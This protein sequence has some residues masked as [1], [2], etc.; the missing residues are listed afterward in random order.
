MGIVKTRTRRLA[1]EE[2]LLMGSQ[3]I[4]ATVGLQTN[5]LR[6]EW[7]RIDNEE[8][9]RLFELCSQASY[10][11]GFNTTRLS[12]RELRTW[13][14]LVEKAAAAPGAFD[15][16]REAG[17]LAVKVAELAT[18]ARKPAPRPVLAE[19][20]SVTLPREWVL[21]FVRDGI[22]QPEDLA[23]LVFILAMFENGQ[24]LSRGT[25]FEGDTLLISDLGLF[26]ADQDPMTRF[27]AWHEALKHLA[28]NNF[29]DVERFGPTWRVKLGSRSL[30]ARKQAA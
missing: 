6:P 8:K 7:D 13:E 15:K 12:R 21:D 26:D 2:L 24:T 5:G 10:G 23:V 22:L 9:L 11:G 18:R 4:R 20:G 17:Q 16:A 19:E 28:T 30:R 3:I 1:P 27:G 29:V 25:R 14:K